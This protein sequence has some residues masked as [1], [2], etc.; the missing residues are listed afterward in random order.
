[1]RRV[2]PTSHWY[3]IFGT[4]SGALIA[5]GGTYYVVWGASPWYRFGGVAA[6]VFG[7]AAFA[8]VMMSRIVLDDEA[9]LVI[10]L[11]RRRCYA[12]GDFESAKVDGGAVVLRR[13][14][15]GSLVLPD[16]GA[17]ALSVRNTIHAWVRRD[18]D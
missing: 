6:I 2:F 10:S 11:A 14:D 3:R 9:L 12:R 1:V 13:R 4:V 18:H 15:G 17:N 5:S 7:L 16:T 8:D